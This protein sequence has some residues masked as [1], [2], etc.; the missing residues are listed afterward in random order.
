MPARS[1]AWLVE[2]S[3]RTTPRK[4]FC[5]RFKT[6]T[7]ELESKLARHIPNLVCTF[8]VFIVRHFAFFGDFQH[9]STKLRRLLQLQKP[10]GSVGSQ[11]DALVQHIWTFARSAKAK[12]VQE[13]NIKSTET[14]RKTPTETPSCYWHCGENM[15]LAIF[16]ALSNRSRSVASF[17]STCHKLRMTKSSLPSQLWGKDPENTK[18]IITTEQESKC[19]KC[20]DWSNVHKN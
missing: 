15:H 2:A 12:N 10:G 5:I 18:T 20:M 1:V 9:L 4:S 6:H 17:L 13:Q 8:K 7:C 3:S 16:R 14:F 11:R 19:M